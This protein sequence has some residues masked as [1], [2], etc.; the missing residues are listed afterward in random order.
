LSA[1]S[2]NSGIRG[3]LLPDERGSAVVYMICEP[4]THYY[5]VM[6]RSDRMP[7]LISERI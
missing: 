4:A 6:T 2:I 5:R 3:V 7:V 1:W